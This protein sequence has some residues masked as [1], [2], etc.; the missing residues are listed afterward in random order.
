MNKLLLFYD[1]LRLYGLYLDLML[2]FKNNV[3]FLNTNS[4]GKK[5]E[6]IFQSHLYQNNY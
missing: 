3:F 2:I 4:T 5:G 6:K 1:S